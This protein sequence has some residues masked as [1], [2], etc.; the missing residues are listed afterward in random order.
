MLEA[1]SKDCKT[2]FMLTCV[3]KC[4][5]LGIMTYAVW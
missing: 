1:L 4:A 3:T 2:H 5:G